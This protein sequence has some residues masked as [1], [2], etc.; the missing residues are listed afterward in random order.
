MYIYMEMEW[1][2]KG[3]ENHCE[4]S[5]LYPCLMKLPQYVLIKKMRGAFSALCPTVQLFGPVQAA[6]LRL[7]PYYHLNSWSCLF[8]EH[9]ACCVPWPSTAVHGA[10][11]AGGMEVEQTRRPNPGYWWVPN[12]HKH[13]HKHMTSAHGYEKESSHAD[14]HPHRTMNVSAK[15]Y[16]NSFESLDNSVYT[17]AW[18]T[19]TATSLA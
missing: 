10:P 6:P 16:G 13:T 11:A 18:P 2:W 15:C 4:V 5:L 9:S 3:D 8:T 14:V 19:N 1:K 7:W 12:I 17:K